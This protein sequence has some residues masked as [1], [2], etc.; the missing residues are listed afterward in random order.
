MTT[1]RL[2]TNPGE[3]QACVWLHLTTLLILPTA[4]LH[5]VAAV[6]L[7]QVKREGSAF[8]DD[9]GREVVNF[10]ISLMVYSFVLGVLGFLILPLIA[11]AA[12]FIVALISI[13]RGAV[14]ANR[15]EVFRYP[16]CLRFIR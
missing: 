2:E 7:W 16:M 1:L 9:H 12:V 11:L 8:A 6:I 14:A 3:R 10:Q 4:V 15:G 5:L 13:I